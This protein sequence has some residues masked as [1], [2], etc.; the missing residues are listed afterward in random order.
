MAAAHCVWAR[1]SDRIRRG[2]R[3]GDR[4]AVL[5]QTNQIAGNFDVL[6]RPAAAAATADHIRT[7]W[8]PCLR[9]VL[10]REFDRHQERFT[11]TARDAIALLKG[12]GAL[13]VNP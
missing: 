13:V 12:Q 8:A 11:P 10:L 4:R 7:F 1:S 5:Y 3:H 6:G 2:G 9:W